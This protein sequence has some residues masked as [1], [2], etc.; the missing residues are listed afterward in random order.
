MKEIEIRNICIIFI[1]AFPRIS[2]I[3]IGRL[4]FYIHFINFIK[5]SLDLLVFIFQIIILVFYFI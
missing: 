5:F 1:T 3:I 2:I 4:I